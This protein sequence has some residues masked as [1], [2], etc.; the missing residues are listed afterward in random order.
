LDGFVSC[1]QTAVKSAILTSPSPFTYLGTYKMKLASLN[2]DILSLNSSIFSCESID[3][4]DAESDATI[5]I[6]LNT[7]QKAQVSFGKETRSSDLNTP[8]IQ[9]IFISSKLPTS[10]ESRQEEFIKNRHQIPETKQK[11]SDLINLQKDLEKWREEIHDAHNEA[12]HTVESE[13]LKIK[14]EFDDQKAFLKR[15]LENTLESFHDKEMLINEHIMDAKERLDSRKREILTPIE[16]LPDLTIEYRD[17][18]KTQYQMLTKRSK[19]LSITKYQKRDLLKN[20][21][22]SFQID[23][24]SPNLTLKFKFDELIVKGC[25]I[26]YVPYL[27]FEY[28]RF[29]FRCG[30]EI[31]FCY[32]R[33]EFFGET[34]VVEGIMKS[35]CV[36][37]LVWTRRNLPRECFIF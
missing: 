19:Y 23:A 37:T 22:V 33:Y 6:N 8:K 4:S 17:G 29:C 1:R 2:D 3:D 27:E 28:R 13:Y 20:P 9:K 34:L 21:F 35:R 31:Q 15:T 7:T 32:D 14:E 12:M 18:L 16:P 10:N 26:G 36:H 25:G 5:K 11:L 24:S 30:S